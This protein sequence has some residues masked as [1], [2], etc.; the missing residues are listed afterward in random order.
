M[1][2]SWREHSHAR[3]YYP[4]PHI[5]YIPI[6][7]APLAQ[8]AFIWRTYTETDLVRAFAQA[9]ADTGPLALYQ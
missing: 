3:H 8:W 7:D 1:R 9:V 5:A 2:Y 6:T 4:H